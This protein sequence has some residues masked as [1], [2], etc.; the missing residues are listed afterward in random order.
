MKRITE[1]NV[2]TS[3]LFPSPEQEP[4]AYPVLLKIQKILD[5]VSPTD[6]AK[7]AGQY[8]DLM[9]TMLSDEVQRIVNA[10]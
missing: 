2:E 3:Y 6:S 4:L 5:L 8:L 10:E 9:I 7:I 1:D